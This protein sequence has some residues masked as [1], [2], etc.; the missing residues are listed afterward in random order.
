V[1]F[2]TKYQMESAIG[3]ADGEWTDAGI[4]RKAI[5]RFSLTDEVSTV[6]YEYDQAELADEGSL[7]VVGT[8][9]DGRWFFFTGSRDY[10]GWD[11]QGGYDVLVGSENEIMAQTPP[12]I[13]QTVW[14][15]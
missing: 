11:C 2:K 6:V 10:T 5:E 12:D 9:N 4:P 8:L 1:D 15:S 7:H 3:Y 14:G 13:R